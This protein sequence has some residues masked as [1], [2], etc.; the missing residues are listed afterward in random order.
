MTADSV[1]MSMLQRTTIQEIAEQAG[2]SAGTVSRILNGKNKENRPSMARRSESVRKIALDMGYRPNAAARSM[3]SGKFDLVAF[4][5]CGTI[6]FDWYPKRVIHGLHDALA[7]QNSRLVISELSRQ[8]FEADQLTP[9]FLQQTMVDG[10][11]T[12]PDPIV[13]HKV[14]DF[15][16]HYRT[17]CVMINHDVPER[18]VFP[19]EL[20]GGRMLAEYVIAKGRRKIGFFHRPQRRLDHY[21][22]HERRNGV[23]EACKASKSKVTFYD[24]EP[25]PR[26]DSY[27]EPLANSEDGVNFLNAHRGIDAVVCY[28]MPEAVAMIMAAVR[29]GLRVP[30]DLLVVAFHESWIYA[31]V[32]F[33]IPTAII[34]FGGVAIAAVKMLNQLVASRTSHQ[35][36]VRVPY[37]NVVD[38]VE[39]DVLS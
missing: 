6:G 33:S 35:P 22:Q 14:L 38:A 32:G 10:V 39:N 26:Q 15:F 17:P 1:K 31:E 3:L 11:V 23:I 25:L 24:H 12:M 29:L 30:D 28:E 7:V 13:A 8:E 27:I 16:K 5:T 18:A 20:G 21:S 37:T 19:D 9:K 36:M 4:I 34:P 2:V